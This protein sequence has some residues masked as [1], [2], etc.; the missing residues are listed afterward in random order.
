MP[1]DSALFEEYGLPFYLRGPPDPE[2]TRISQAGGLGVWIFNFLCICRNLSLI[3][4]VRRHQQCED[5][6]V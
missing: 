4:L 5:F 6:K 2:A 1:L 3:L